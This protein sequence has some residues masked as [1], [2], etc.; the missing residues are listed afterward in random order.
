[1]KNRH[2]VRFI[3]TDTCLRVTRIRRWY[4][5]RYN[6]HTH[7]LE[8]LEYFLPFGITK[9]KLDIEQ[10]PLRLGATTATA[11]AAR[12]A[13]KEPETTRERDEHS[14]NI[15]V[16]LLRVLKFNCALICTC[17]CACVTHIR[18]VS[19]SVFY[20]SLHLHFVSLS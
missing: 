7:T 10:M 19:R 9:K 18:S 11:A 20:F 5:I 4:E 16:Q 6:T 17:L 13:V 15:H 14:K 12:A 2:T 8:I 3:H 1:M